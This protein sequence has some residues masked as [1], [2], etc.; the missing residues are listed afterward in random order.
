MNAIQTI[1]VNFKELLDQLSICFAMVISFLLFNTISPSRMSISTILYFSL[2]LVTNFIT[3]S[4]LS[5]VPAK[6][7]YFLVHTKALI[8]NS[9]KIKIDKS[10][11]EGLAAFPLAPLLENVFRLY[12]TLTP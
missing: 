4:F 12:H 1:N 7:M 3:K 9:S 8:D 6:A 2:M 11:I 10:I 5:E